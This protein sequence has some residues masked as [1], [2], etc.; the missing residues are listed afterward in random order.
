MS[1]FNI[2]LIILGGGGYTIDNVAKVWAYDTS[3][4]LGIEISKDLPYNE[5]LDYYGPHYKLEIPKLNIANMNTIQDLNNIVESIYENLRNVVPVPS[6]QM[7]RTPSCFIEEESDE[8]IYWQKIMKDCD[9]AVN[10]PDLRSSGL[11]EE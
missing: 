8:E 9:T 1:H 11:L 10:Y 4:A 3:V 6:V 2:P 5:Y 7:T